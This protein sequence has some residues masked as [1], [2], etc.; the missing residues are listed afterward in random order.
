MAFRKEFPNSIT[1]GGIVVAVEDAPSRNAPGVKF[2]LRNPSERED[3]ATILLCRAY[4]KRMHEMGMGLRPGVDVVIVTGRVEVL[5]Y[6]TVIVQE[7]FLVAE[8]DVAEDTFDEDSDDPD[9]E[10]PVQRWGTMPRRE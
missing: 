2:T 5:N 10:E 9:D 6:P 4:G 3:R 7:L 1:F 8:E